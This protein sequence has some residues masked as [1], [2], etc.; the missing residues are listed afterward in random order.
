MEIFRKWLTGKE[1]MEKLDITQLDL[2]ELIKNGMLPIYDPAGN[3]AEVK[4]EQ[5]LSPNVISDWDAFAG[6]PIQLTPTGIN[7]VDRPKCVRTLD[8]LEKLY[9]ASIDVE[10]LEDK[11][12]KKQRQTVKKTLFPCKL[13][14]RWEDI[15]ITLTADDKV[16][17][18]TPEGEGHFS[19]HEIGL[20]DGRKGDAPTIL[21]EFLKI[22][23]KNNGF[24]SYSNLQY[25]K[26]IP[27]W[28]KRLNKHLKDLFG[29]N[30][31]IYEGHYKA[32][33]GY[34]T[35]IQFSNQTF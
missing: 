6:P 33:K 24:I 22:L 32:Q 2:W 27:N 35:K 9:F 5:A 12:T 21:W 13:G 15:I 23:A 31:S 14:T 18:K 16:R 1:V 25:D 7:F 8:E 34:R 3:Q 19:Y 26:N 4:I 29:I 10:L 20:S 30:E 17:I 28:A 11:S